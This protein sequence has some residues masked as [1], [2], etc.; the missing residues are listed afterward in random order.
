MCFG[1]LEDA[2]AAIKSLHETSVGDRKIKVKRALKPG[3]TQGGQSRPGV[4]GGRGGYSGGRG[5]GY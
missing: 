3:D 1:T 2:E 5:R 4:I